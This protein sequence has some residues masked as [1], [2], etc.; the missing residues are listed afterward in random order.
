MYKLFALLI[1]LLFCPLS[2]GQSALE[3]S[4]KTGDKFVIQQ[5]AEQL[6][7]QEFDGYTHE[8]NN[9]INGILEFVVSGVDS[10]IYEIDMIFRDLGMKISSNIQGEIMN[11]RAAELVESD[12]QSRIFHSLLN[13]PVKILLDKRGHVTSVRGGEKLVEKMTEASGITDSISKQ[14]LRESLAGEFGSVALSNS[15]EQMTYIYPDKDSVQDSSWKNEYRGKLS[16]MNQWTLEK[17]SDSINQIVGSANIRMNITDPGTTMLLTGE[18]QTHIKADVNTGFIIE[19]SV[20][21][22]ASGT[23]MSENSGDLEIPTTISSTTTYK[24]LRD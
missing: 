9:K 5:D 2:H 21:G 20:E 18:Q 1:F 17:T 7:V 6:V 11:I 24:Q 22:M 23:A 16:A 13:V 15:F 10:E 12:P 14:A 19:M 3:Y 8:L 4:L